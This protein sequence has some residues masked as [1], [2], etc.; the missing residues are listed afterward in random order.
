MK[1]GIHLYRGHARSRL[2]FRQTFLFLSYHS[3]MCVAVD[4]MDC[5]AYASLLPYL[6]GRDLHIFC[7]IL[8]KMGELLKS[9]CF[10][11]CLSDKR[12]PDAT[13]SFY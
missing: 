3:V 4:C 1:E 12:G 13:V 6:I 7:K 11:S 10:F 2:D 9:G 8:P 5:V